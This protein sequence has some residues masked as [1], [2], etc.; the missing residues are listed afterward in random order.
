[1]LRARAPP[2]FTSSGGREAPSGHPPAPTSCRRARVRLRL[3]QL[4]ETLAGEQFLV[5]VR[6]APPP[7]PSRRLELLRALRR[8]RLGGG[9]ASVAAARSR[10]A[11]AGRASPARSAL[12]PASASADALAAGAFQ[13]LRDDFCSSARSHCEMCCCRSAAPAPCARLGGLERVELCRSPRAAALRAR[14]LLGRAETTLARYA[15]VEAFLSASS[16]FFCSRRSTSSRRDAFASA[17]SACRVVRKSRW[18]FSAGGGDGVVGRRGER[19]TRRGSP[20]AI[21]RVGWGASGQRARRVSAEGIDRAARDLSHL[22]AVHGG[23]VLDDGDVERVG[24]GLGGGELVVRRRERGCGRRARSDTAC[25]GGA[26][27]VRREFLKQPLGTGVLAESDELRAET[28]RA[29]RSEGGS[30]ARA[31]RTALSR[32]VLSRRRRRE[33]SRDRTFECSSA[34]GRSGSPW[35]A[36]GARR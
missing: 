7:P 6:L 33:R 11:E 17:S 10:C 30:R 25:E 12:A 3:V 22:Q 1:M 24:V 13:Q 20:R 31:P 36:T 27:G 9:R 5:E 4:G 23:G 26:R 19:K 14:A 16:A 34:S 15:P 35:L 8:R 28:R 32:I 21:A 29:G 2:S 18:G